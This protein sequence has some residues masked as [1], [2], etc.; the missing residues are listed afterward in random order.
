MNKLE[1]K[2]LFFLLGILTGLFISGIILVLVLNPSSHQAGKVIFAPLSSDFNIT[3]QENLE[4]FEGKINLNRAT[5]EELISL[6][7][8]GPVKAKAIIEFRDKYGPFT[9][10]E[11]L[12]YIPGIGKDQLIV[13]APLL[14]IP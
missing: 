5:M 1:N 14:S 11:E 6:P 13:I 4:P 9:E 2:W 8:I 7:G 10:I 3:K 12:L